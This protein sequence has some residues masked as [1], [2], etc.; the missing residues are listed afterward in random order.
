MVVITKYN[1]CPAEVTYGQIVIKN[2]K[3]AGR[4]T[5]QATDPDVLY[6]SVRAGNRR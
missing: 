3:K 1:I 2:Q 4:R 6:S 5:E